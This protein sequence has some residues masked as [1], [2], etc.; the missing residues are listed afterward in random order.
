MSP[1]R[2][3]RTQ[4]AVA[5]LISAPRFAPYVGDA[6]GHIKN[7]LRLYQ[8]NI[9]LSM[10]YHGTLQVFEV[11][12]RNAIDQR[13]RDWNQ[14]ENGRVDWLVQPAPL[15]ERLVGGNIKS[16]CDRACRN[17]SAPSHDD[18]LA[19]T[20]LGTWR[21]L[22]YSADPG[23]RY[24]WDAAVKHSFP[25]MKSERAVVEAVCKVHDLRNRIAHNEP[26]YRLNPGLYTDYMRATIATI[27]VRAAQWM[28][29][30]STINEVAKAQ[31]DFLAP[32]V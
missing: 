21:Y 18:I 28:I 11:F 1:Q 23:K 25:G 20:S 16:A 3:D 32:A 19:Q 7:A 8:W 30:F 13:L 2:K 22:M 14:G 15:L 26:I 17:N 5:E 12:L 10:A 24:L 27:D 31:P 29:S 9:D 6:A 4:Q